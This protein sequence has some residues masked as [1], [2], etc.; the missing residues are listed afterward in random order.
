MPG[1]RTELVFDRPSG[2][3]VATASA[4]APGE[5]SEV[6]WADSDGGTVTEQF[7]AETDDLD[8]FERIFDYGSKTVYEFEETQ[9]E[10]AS[11][12]CEYIERTLG[13]I[14]DVRA[15]DGRLSVTLH[16]A[17]VDE[18]RETVSELGDRFG[19]VT[20]EY[21]VRSVEREDRTDLVPVDLRRLTDRQREVLETAH[22]LGY[23]E[24]PRD[25]NAG[26][27]ADELGIEPSTFAEHLA[28][29][30]GKLLEEL[31]E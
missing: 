27:V 21:L 2:C 29:A 24:Y 13:P 7:A 6:T 28:A 19:S 16:A 11:C 17:D 25:A 10:R 1:V 5:L 31:I 4:D 26:D 22:R 30:Q 9:S 3:P 20:V 14:R 23:F 12:I 8:G 18:L 15:R